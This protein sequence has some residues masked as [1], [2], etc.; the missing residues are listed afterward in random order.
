MHINLHTAASGHPNESIGTASSQLFNVNGS[1]G[2]GGRKAEQNA[3]QS[4]G[5]GYVFMLVSDEP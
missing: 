5:I 3:V 4:A 2:F 1:G